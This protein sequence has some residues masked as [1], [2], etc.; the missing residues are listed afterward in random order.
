MHIMYIILIF[1]IYYYVLSYVWNVPMILP[2]GRRVGDMLLYP[3]F[4]SFYCKEFY[5]VIL[6]Y[7][8]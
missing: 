5:L 7:Y 2:T 8:M 6:L 3:Y 1:Y 4:I